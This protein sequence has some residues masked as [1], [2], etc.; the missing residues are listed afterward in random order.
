MLLMGMPPIALRLVSPPRVGCRG[1]AQRGSEL[2]THNHGEA[3]QAVL[4]G[5]KF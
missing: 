4:A 5:H 2:L 1:T 3:E